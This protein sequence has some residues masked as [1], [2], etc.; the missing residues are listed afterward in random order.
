M[1]KLSI[2]LVVL[3]GLYSCSNSEVKTA[4]PYKANKLFLKAVTV[5]TDKTPS[6]PIIQNKPISQNIKPGYYIVQLQVPITQSM[7]QSIAQTGVNILNY[8]P[9]N[10]F[11]IRVTDTSTLTKLNS[12]NTVKWIG[13]YKSQYKISPVL[14]NLALS[15]SGSAVTVTVQV[16]RSGDIQAVI[17]AIKSVSG[18]II[19]MSVTSTGSF[20]RAQVTYSQINTIANIPDV[21]W[22]ELYRAPRLMNNV[23]TDIIGASN[24]NT[25]LNPNGVW[26]YGFTGVGQAVA[27]ADTGLDIGNSSGNFVYNAARG[28]YETN[29]VTAP[30]HPAFIGKAIHAYALGRTGDFSDPFGHGTHVAGSLLGHDTQTAF[31][32]TPY[33]GSAYGVD[34]VVFMSVLDATGGLGGLPA[35]LN[36]LFGQEYTDTLSPRIASNSW[37]SNANGAY[38]TSAEQVDTFLWDHPD[39]AILFAAGNAGVDANGDGVVDLGSVGSPATAK[40]VITVGASENLRSGLPITYYSFGFISY[41]IYSDLVANNINGMAAFSSRGPTSD[42]RIKPDLVAPG[43][44]IISARSHQYP[45]N[46]D[47]QNGA[48]K[49]SVTP[50]NTWK[51]F[52][53]GSGNSYEQIISNGTNLTGNLSPINPIDIRTSIDSAL[54]FYINCNLTTSDQ[55]TI[56]FYDKDNNVSFSIYTLS[57]ASGSGIF[58]IPVSY[59]FYL[60][61]KAINYNSTNNYAMTL[62]Q[63]KYFN[64][65]LQFTSLSTSAGTAYVDIDNVRVCPSGWGILG[66]T[67]GLAP[68][69]TYGSQEDENYILDG[70]TSMATPL[71][72]GAAADVRQAIVQ[73]GISDPSAALVKAVL[74]NGAVDMYPGQYGTGQYL[75]MPQAPNNVEGFGRINLVNSLISGTTKKIYM[76]DYTAGNGLTTGGMRISYVTINNTSDPL[77]LTLVWT[78][79]P[80]TPS[81]S[82]NIVNVLHFSMTTTNNSIFYPNGLST[83]DDIDNVQQITLP[84]PSTGTYTVYVSGYNVPQGT[85]TAGD[86]PY[87]LVISGDIQNLSATPPTVAPSPLSIAV[88]PY[89]LN[90][91]AIVGSS[92]DLTQD[93]SINSAGPQGSTLIWT[94][95]SN[96]PWIKTSITNGT[97]PSNI[98]VIANP[99]NLKAG[100]YKGSIVITA[101][102]AVN[103]PLTLP[104]TLIVT[105]TAN[106]SS[107]NGYSCSI[108]SGSGKG[109]LSDILVYLLMFIGFIL[110][111]KSSLQWY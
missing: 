29:D 107:S 33:W 7:K 53:D 50:A 60:H 11:I 43:T 1:K 100:T 26:N 9:E 90:F 23:A 108:S 48:G 42:G 2:L 109:D 16:F 3:I 99:A 85:S 79:Y 81:A 78:D 95:Q 64:F 63:A 111:K 56:Y 101:D 18:Q 82:V 71:A 28:D 57:N 83:Y 22:I 59:Y 20:I 103:S 13:M 39:M 6:L 55:F 105:S 89:S 35:D 87:A 98:T 74:I 12:I 27:I 97:T 8:L 80:S 14:T 32:S 38:D 47:F 46:D 75:E 17:D 102:N 86:Q 41:P 44:A 72:A 51:L 4:A 65:S 92:K 61:N 21:Q 52:T 68:T 49:W 91:T 67:S 88:L 94:V 96:T 36:T 5:D 106:S 77:K 58:E 93:V 45:F 69:I 70:G 19:T 40:D 10:A 84:S 73:N 30:F 37:G 34:K 76:L 66:L 62:N 54:F 104:V 15:N 24:N 110:I 25:S 31:S